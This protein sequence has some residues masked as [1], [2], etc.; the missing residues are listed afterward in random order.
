MWLGLSL[1]AALLFATTSFFDKYLLNK[2]TRNFS[3]ASYIALSSIA[4]LPILIVLYFLARSS[5]ANYSGW[6]IATALCA[7]LLLVSGYYLFFRCLGFADT[8]I[9][10]ILFQMAVVFNLIFGWI[11]LHEHLGAS[12]ITGI[13]L[14]LVGAT[15]LNIEIDGGKFRFKPGVFI[16]MLGASILVSL[17]DVLFKHTALSANYIGT[18]FFSYLSIT[19][20]GAALY[21]LF[22]KIRRQLSAFIRSKNKPLKIS[23]A[24]EAINASGVLLVNYALILGPIALVQAA[25]SVEAFFAV[26]IGIFLTRYFPKIIKE[27]VGRGHVAIKIFSCLI[28]IAGISLIS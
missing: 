26:I 5:L 14:I 23:T 17:S 12:A 18:Q 2:V 15:V 8:S 25:V 7:G 24:N 4:G 1:F 10:A 11:F 22:P 20:T 16:P 6:T 27:N 28:I 13:I 3:A 19:L 9:V 21:I